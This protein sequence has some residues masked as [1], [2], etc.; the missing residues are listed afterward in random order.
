MKSAGPDKEGAFRA[1]LGSASRGRIVLVGG[2]SHLV[3]KADPAMKDLCR[4]RFF[5]EP[6]PGVRIRRSTITVRYPRLRPLDGSRREYSGEVVLGTRVPWRIGFGGG[7]VSRLAVDLSGLRLGSF[8]VEDGASRVELRL[9]T[10]SGS[11]PV[12]FR[13]GASNV[14]VHR[15]AGVA[16]RLQVSGGVTNLS[17]D[18]RHFGVVAD[19]VDL[20]TPDYADASDR[21]D[22]AVTGGANNLTFDAA[23]PDHSALA[24]ADPPVTPREKEGE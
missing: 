15:P 23:R 13:G 21:Y 8:E 11:V 24:G 9:P 4:A 6:V 14:A 3:I 2:A 1:P 16:T 20:Q 18:G 10:P 19:E 5:E 12:R 22:I 7:G 17:F